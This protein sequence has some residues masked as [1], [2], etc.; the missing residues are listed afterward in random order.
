MSKAKKQGRDG[1]AVDEKWRSLLQNEGAKLILRGPERGSPLH[2]RA[3]MIDKQITRID[4]S[5]E[6]DAVAEPKR[7]GK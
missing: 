5:Q 3:S 6:Q 7:K 2:T 1:K 4:A